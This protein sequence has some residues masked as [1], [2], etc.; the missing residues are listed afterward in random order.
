MPYDPED[1]DTKA[2]IAAAVEAA[3]IEAAKPIQSALNAA[4]ANLATLKAERDTLA[5]KAT[6][7]EEA[8]RVATESGTATASEIAALKAKVEAADAREAAAAKATLDARLAALP[9]GVRTKA[10]T[11]PAALSTWLEIAEAMPAGIPGR[12]AAGGTAAPEPTPEMLAWARQ[13]W[14]AQA[15]HITPANLIATYTKL[16]SA[17]LTP[18]VEA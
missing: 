18:A 3:K 7:A 4:A 13:K 12:T 5:A 16:K 15:E 10:P 1:A 9:E 14:G 8:L 2:A 17:G 11:D 6:A